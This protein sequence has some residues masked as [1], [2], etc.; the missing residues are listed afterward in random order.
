[1]AKLKFITETGMF[2]VACRCETK[3][4]VEWYGFKP[5]KHR[6][7]VSPGF[8]DMSDRSALLNHC[9]AFDVPDS[10]LQ[11]SLT[12]AR[13]RYNGETYVLGVKDCVS[14]GAD[15]ARGAGLRVPLVNMTP[16]GFIRTLAMWNKSD[17]SA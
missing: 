17:A 15:I 9:I 16:Y 14:F 12:T 6:V 11:G 7:A 2:H 8:V 5:L 3:G 10:A 1:M 13:A 4:R